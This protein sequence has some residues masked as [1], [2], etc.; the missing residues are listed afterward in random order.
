M[1]LIENEAEVDRQKYISVLVGSLDT[2]MKHFLLSAFY[3][4]AV[5]VLIAV[6]FYTL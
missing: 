4:K 5:A 6:L 1:F 2:Q 3:L